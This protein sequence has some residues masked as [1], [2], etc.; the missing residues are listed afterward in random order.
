[1]YTISP[2]P[3]PASVVDSS[4]FLLLAQVPIVTV[5]SSVILV[6]EAVDRVAANVPVTVT[7][8]EVVSNF[9]TSS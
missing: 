2:S 6:C 3:L 7:P 4:N 8:A 9:F 1:M 5:P